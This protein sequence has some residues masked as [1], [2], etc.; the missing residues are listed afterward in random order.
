MNE[1]R[2]AV[3]GAGHL[4][5]IHTRLARNL[6]GARL[7]GLVE[8]VASIR[9]KVADEM[10]V[11]GFAHHREIVD[12]ID[13]A[14]VATP[15]HSHHE[16]ALELINAGKH[17]LVEKPITS[18]LAQADELIAAAE[19]RDVVLAVGHVERFNPALAAARPHLGPPKYI[20]AARTGGYTFRSTDV[21]V[22]LDL[23]I[24]DLDVILSLVGSPLVDVQALGAAVFGPHEDMVQ[25]R[26]V[27]AQGCVANITASRTSFAAQRRMQIYSD[28]G[29][30]DIDFATRQTQVVH[31]GSLL[32][33]RRLDVSSLGEE[34][35]QHIRENLFNDQSL[36]PLRTV[37][38]AEA[39]P[40]Q[41]EQQDF[42]DAI[43]HGRPPRVTGQAG[44]DALFA[45]GQ[46]LRSVARHQWDGS[47]EG[48]V[49]PHVMPAAPTHP[50]RKAA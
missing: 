44:R 16:V 10:Q 31:L 47:P 2:L 25:A 20:E 6:Q 50:Q 34:R 19:V 35:K 49:G 38:A 18:T 37:A 46:V 12:R 26:I 1:I 43:R 21:S 8:P 9:E 36:L 41:D 23:M 13:A 4:G 48:R 30:A 27:F 40:L 45:A 3:V 33:G 39:N 14:V 32:E 29:F 24:H 5:R 17:L 28:R 7:V 42:C 22:V 15:T 11:P